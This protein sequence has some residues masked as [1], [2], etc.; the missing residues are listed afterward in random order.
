[1]DSWLSKPDEDGFRAALYDGSKAELLGLVKY[2]QDAAHDG[3]GGN[4]RLI[5]NGVKH[6][7]LSP[8]E[9]FFFAE[10]MREG[11]FMPFVEKMEVHLN[12]ITESIYKLGDLE[13]M[14]IEDIDDDDYD[15]GRDEPRQV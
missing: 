2:L 10:G 8:R 7:F 14:T 11:A 3:I 9:L 4:F 6:E 5:L 12:A 13:E 15:E 1:M